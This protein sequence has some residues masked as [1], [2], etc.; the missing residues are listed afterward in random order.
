MFLCNLVSYHCETQA[1]VSK[2][3][4]PTTTSPTSTTRR[5][6]KESLY[7]SNKEGSAKIDAPFFMPSWWVLYAFFMV[8]AK[9]LKTNRIHEIVCKVYKMLIYSIIIV[10]TL[11]D[12]SMICR[13]SA[14][15]TI[16]LFLFIKNIFRINMCYLLLSFRKWFQCLLW[17]QSLPHWIKSPCSH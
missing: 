14:H 16:M 17:V 5:W 11:G 13:R 3:T 4:T 10:R 9:S 2:A 7:I 8:I 6:S 12:P 15:H 1:Q